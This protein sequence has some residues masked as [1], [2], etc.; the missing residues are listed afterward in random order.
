VIPLVSVV[1]PT[2]NSGR[3]I[4]ACLV[5]IRGQTVHG[6]EVVV[7]DN[8]ST[9]NTV[10]I[11]RKY[12]DRVQAGGPERSAQRN[13]GARLATG[14][15]LLFIDSD[16][17]LE[18]N[19][20]AECIEASSPPVYPP[21]VI[22]EVTIGEG[23]WSRCR[24][25]ERNCYQGDNLVEAARFFSR[26]VFQEHGGYDEGL[27]G[28]EDWDLSLRA[29][30]GRPPSRIRS[31]IFHDEGRVRLVALLAKKRYY[32]ASFPAYWRKHG[33]LTIRQSNI[34][35]RP[36]FIR[37]WRALVRQPLLAIGLFTLKFLEAG[38]ALWGIID[39]KSSSR[40]RHRGSGR[41]A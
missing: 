26:T 16:M 17:V 34:V 4:E 14:Q 13:L 5:S 11:A 36:A 38:A 39:G 35:L 30:R 32:A 28:P 33:S 22:P 40:P 19:V 6:I 7:V 9:D 12:A 31:K 20:V 3:T 15:Y 21:V 29:S 41:V 2:R 27:T 23:F 1:V 25:L 24:T 8:G 37:E 18:R 10:E